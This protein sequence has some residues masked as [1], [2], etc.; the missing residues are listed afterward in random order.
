[1]RNYKQSQ[2]VEAI[3][4]SFCLMIF[5]YFIHSGFPV[6]IISFTALLVP[7]YIFGKNLQS[8]SDI[9]KKPWTLSSLLILQIYTL[10]GFLTGMLLAMAYRWYLGISLLPFSGPHYFIIV[11]CLIGA[12]E[13]LVFRGFIQEYA[14]SINAPFSVFF[15]SIS[16]TGYKCC[17][18]LAPLAAADID[19]KF[20]ALWTFGAGILFGSLK[21]FS[22]S[23][24][25]PLIAHV[26]FDL[27]VYAEFLHA[28]WWVW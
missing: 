26:I 15:G 16:H 9:R 12:L 20:L 8:F 2:I 3:L 14:K 1:M 19:I 11:A 7:A 5:S 6:R 18:F 23:I 28:P 22:K 24:F 13:E 21:H 27:F 10:A 4:C 17:L 25:P